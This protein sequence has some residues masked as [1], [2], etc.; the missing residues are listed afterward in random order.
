MRDPAQEPALRPCLLGAHM[1]RDVLSSVLDGIV[2]SLHPGKRQC[3]L[4][5]ASPRHCQSLSVH[6]NAMGSILDSIASSVHLRKGQPAE[7]DLVAMDADNTDY[8]ASGE[9]AAAAPSRYPA[10]QAAPAALPCSSC[11]P[12]RGARPGYPGTALQTYSTPPP[13]GETAQL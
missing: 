13:P 8:T 10:R 12:P 5:Q 2:A 6:R 11:R 7:P 4:V 1:V 9:V 3:R